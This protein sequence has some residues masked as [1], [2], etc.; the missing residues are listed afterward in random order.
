MAKHDFASNPDDDR[1]DCPNCGERIKAQ[2]IV[3]RFCESGLSPEHFKPCILCGEMIRTEATFCRF[4]KSEITISVRDQQAGGKNLTHHREIIASLITATRTSDD[5]DSIAQSAIESMM[6]LFKAD[7]GLIWWING[8]T[9]LVWHEA[10][11]NGHTCFAGNTLGMQE[12]TAFVLDLLSRFPDKSGSGA[13]CINRVND[14][15]TLPT[16]TALMELGDVYSRMISQIRLRGIICGAVELQQCSAPRKWDAQIG[17]A[18]NEI[19]GA[20]ALLLRHH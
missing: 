2:A 19:A 7:R 4:C 14:Y 5:F 15:G 11:S 17:T 18:L 12:S 1:V 10:T 16:V 13:V 8:D 9:V 3:C 6:T 20:L